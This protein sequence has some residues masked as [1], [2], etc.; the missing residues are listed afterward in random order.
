VLR[1][2]FIESNED[3]HMRIVVAVLML[4][5]AVAFLGYA[6]GLDILSIADWK[7]VATTWSVPPT[8]EN[9]RCLALLLGVVFGFLALVRIISSSRPVS[10]PKG[11][12]MLP[13]H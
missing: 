9:E 11:D 4:V 7:S 2:T 13:A 12:A 8:A 3:R 1:G 5:I 10:A 6:G